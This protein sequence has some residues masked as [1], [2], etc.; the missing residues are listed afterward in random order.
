MTCLRFRI[1]ISC[2]SAAFELPYTPPVFSEISSV[3][4]LGSESKSKSDCKQKH[5]VTQSILLPKA[6]S[7]ASA[8][9]K[10]FIFNLNVGLVNNQSVVCYPI[11]IENVNLKW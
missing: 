1:L 7:L 5:G 3:K 10:L 8:I 2:K 6:T 4:S 11:S 9:Q